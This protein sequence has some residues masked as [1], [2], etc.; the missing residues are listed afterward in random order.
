MD[1]DV[2]IVGSGPTGMVLAA[3]LGKAGRS[4]LLLER[5]EGLYQLPRAAAFDDE[6]MRTFQALGVAE[7]MLPGTNVQPG[8]VWVNG[9]DDVLLDIAFDNPGP[10]GWPSQ[11]MMFQPHVEDVLNQLLAQT[12]GVEVR[13]GHEVVGL[14]ERGDSGQTDGV[15]VDVRTRDGA[16]YR[17]SARWVVGCDGGNGFVRR[18]LGGELDEYGF[19]ENWL[20]CDFELRREVPG[21]PAFRQVCDP[22]EPIAIVN[23][24]PRHHRFSF[25]L[26]AGADR[27]AVV[28]PEAVWPRVSRYLGP[29]D[30]DLVRVANYAFQSRCVRQWRRGRVFLAGDAAHEM[31]PFLAQGMVSGIRDARN[32]AWKLDHVLGG[33]TDDVLDTYQAEREPHV[34]FIL[35]KAIELGRVQTE[36]NPE[37]ARERDT[38]MLAARRAHTA[39]DKLRYPPLSGGLVE[40]H[41]HLL[42]QG[43]VSSAE[44]TA[45]FDDV[46]GTG[47]RLVVSSPQVLDALSVEAREGL[48]ALGCRDVVF[49]LSGTFGGAPLADTGGVYSRF[50]SQTGSVAAL[51]RPDGCVYGLAHDEAELVATTK[52]LLGALALA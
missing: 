33:G 6:T 39:P 28:R 13:R 43:V 12:P 27:A 20:V 22:A 46:V 25:R 50:F 32:L 21:L 45:L 40:N 36:R 30:A 24:G 42:P 5:Y 8:Y 16:T 31:P 10:C 48:A 41:G 52:G 34:R 35:E 7:R 38:R 51:V 44:R 26:E 17:V 47:W 11:F 18:H 23:I 3:L 14:T 4:V 49:C 19:S 1:A 2:V 37:R 29:D 9:Q 15:D